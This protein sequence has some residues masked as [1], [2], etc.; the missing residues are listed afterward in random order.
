MAHLLFLLSLF[1]LLASSAQLTDQSEEEVE[2]LKHSAS[3]LPSENKPSN[4]VI[5][6]H[7]HNYKQVFFE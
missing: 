2:L 1:T 6:I 4:H 5:N 7:D 3:S